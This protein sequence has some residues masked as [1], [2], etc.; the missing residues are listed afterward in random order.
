MA[1]RKNE[2]YSEYY[3]R[4]RD[5]QLRYNQRAD[6]KKRSCER[7]RKGRRNLDDFYVKEMLKR[8]GLPVTHEF[9]ELY[10]QHLILKRQI[11]DK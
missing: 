3:Q 7:R 1:K 6:V 8:M 2:A 9:M 10:R 11:Q 5:I 4:H